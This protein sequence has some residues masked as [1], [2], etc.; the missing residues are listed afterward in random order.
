MTAIKLWYLPSFYGDIRLE[1]AGNRKTKVVWFKLSEAEVKALKTL[2]KEATSGLRPWSKDEDWEAHPLKAFEEGYKQE[3]SIV[4]RTGIRKIEKILT[5]ALRPDRDVVR[6]V[7]FSDRQI[8]E[9]RGDPYREEAE[10]EETTAI[11]KRDP[12]P[13]ATTVAAP[14]RGCPAP[15]FETVHLRANRVLKAFLTRKQI[16]DFKRHQRFIVYGAD[17]GHRYMLTSRN[18]PS[19]LRSFAGRTV[20]DLEEDRAYCVHDWSIPAEEELLTMALFLQLPRRETYI[21]EIPDPLRPPTL[22]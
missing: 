14:V 22:I 11:A 19:E 10:E 16:T 18:A 17:T 12:S 4:L 13:V 2:R 8:E 1:A 21:R 5:K 9:V 3:S 20:Y 6:V 15:D 7:R